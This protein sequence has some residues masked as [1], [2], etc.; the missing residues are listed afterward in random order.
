MQNFKLMHPTCVHIYQLIRP[1]FA[2]R[3]LSSESYYFPEPPLF[4]SP[5]SHL[6]NDL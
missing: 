5:I 4:P 3:S 1:L 6:A 2:T